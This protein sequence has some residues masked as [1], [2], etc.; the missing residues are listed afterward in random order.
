MEK[1]VI[2]LN[3]NQLKQIVT[4]SVKKILKEEYQYDACEDLK[5]TI[6]A[7]LET[8]M[9]NNDGIH[10]DEKEVKESKEHFFDTF[11]Y[12]KENFPD[13]DL[14]KCI[15]EAVYMLKVTLDRE[16]SE[17]VDYFKSLINYKGE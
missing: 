10:Y 9:R 12:V 2:K 16:L 6:M 13:I 17:S 7:F 4:E 3:E 1:N 8:Y 5:T 15:S 11:N 14:S